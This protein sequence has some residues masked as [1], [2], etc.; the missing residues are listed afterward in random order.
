MVVFPNA[1]INLGLNIIARRSDGY[2]D[3]DMVMIP[4]KWCDILEVVPAKGNKTTLTTSGCPVNCPPEKNLVY[5]AWLLLNDYVDGDLPAADIY[6]H[7]IIP[8]GAGLGGGSSD[9]AFTLVALNKLFALD[10]SD[11]EL[12]SIASRLGADCPFFIYNRPMLCRETGTTMTPVDVNMEGI[13]AIVIAKPE[14][15]SVSTA[16]A[17]SGVKPETPETTTDIIVSLPPSQWHDRLANGFERHIFQLKPEI[18]EVKRRII[19]GGA[20]Y[21]SMSGSGSAVYGLFNDV[22]LA[23]QTMQNL[24]SCVCHIDRLV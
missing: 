12:C 8:D 7:K 20:V 1:K 11:E 21:A 6:L 18:A 2:H 23:E 13:T 4:V 19:D 17:Y 3:L 24:P 5:K 15:V 14:N 16:E 9:A 22:R 10:M